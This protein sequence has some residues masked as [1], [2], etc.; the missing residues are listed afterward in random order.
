[1]LTEYVLIKQQ[2]L[3]LIVREADMKF[4]ANFCNVTTNHEIRPGEIY[5]LSFRMDLYAEAKTFYV[6]IGIALPTSSGKFESFIQNSVTD[7]CKYL[8]RNNS[9]IMLRLFFNGHFGDKKF[10]TTC[11]VKSDVYYI[12]KFRI[13]EN[14][15]TIRS[16]Q[17]KILIAV[18]FCIDLPQKNMHCILNTKFEAEVKDRQKWLQEVEMRRQSND[19]I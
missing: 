1:M 3:K 14:M 17:T 12:E 19:K 2:S 5:S 18:D 10:P 9:N 6:K 15:L 13:K 4:D 8:K 7:V 11:P 16:I